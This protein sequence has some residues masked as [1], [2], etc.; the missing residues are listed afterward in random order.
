MEVNETSGS[1]NS[2]RPDTVVPHSR[3]LKQCKDATTSLMQTTEQHFQRP[4]SKEDKY[5]VFGR[6]V[7]HKLRDIQDNTQRL[8]MEKIIND[9][10]FMG[11]MNQLTM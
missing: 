9:A 1:V 11:A 5:D 10:L 3:P 6:N 4:K 8:L 2:Q 7:A